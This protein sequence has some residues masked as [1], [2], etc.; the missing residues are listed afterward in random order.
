MTAWI[1][2]PNIFTLATIV[3]IY[4][5]IPKAATITADF[6]KGAGYPL[7]KSKINLYTT[8][9]P[10]TKNFERDIPW[11]AK[12]RPEVLRLE[13]FWGMDQSLS[14]TVSGTATNPVYD[15]A[16]I[17][18]WQKLVVDQGSLV[19]WGYGY[20]PFPLGDGSKNAFKTPPPADPWKRIVSDV[21]THLKGGPVSYHEVWN[22]PN[23]DW[24]FTGGPTDYFKIYENT[25]VA[26]KAVNPDAKV[27]GPTVSLPDWYQGFVQYVQAKNLPLDFFSYHNY[28]EMAHEWTSLVNN[29]LVAD[30][31]F[32]KT[33]TSLDE[34]N[35]YHSWPAGGPQDKFEGANE[36]LFSF[37]GF[38]DRPELTSVFWAQ[39]MDPCDCGGIERLGLLDLNG[40]RKATYNAFRIWAM[41]PVDRNTTQS[42]VA[43]VIAVASSDAHHAG[44]LLLNRTGSDQSI[45]VNFK[46][47]PFA[48]G[49]V[50]VFPIDKTHNSLGDGANEDLTASQTISNASL[51]A[52]SWTGS[53]PN[54]GTLYLDAQDA[55]KESLLNDN[56]VAKI[57]HV[58]HYYPERG[59]TK[60]Y[61]EFDR[62]T[63]I[64]RLGMN[65][66]AVS[67][68]EVGVTAEGL[69]AK[70][71][72]KLKVEGNLVRKD[73][74]SLLGMRIDFQQTD[75]GYSK[76]VLFH[77]SYQGSLDLYDAARTSPMPYG[78]NKQASQSVTVPDLASFS[79]ELAKYA[80]MDWTG[81]TQILFI[82]QNTGETTR[83]IFQI[84]G[85]A[86]SALQFTRNANQYP[87]GS[88]SLLNIGGAT[89]HRVLEVLNLNGKRI[90]R[91]GQSDGLLAPG[92]H[93]LMESH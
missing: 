63:W 38:L 69:P 82:M 17:D 57:I 5:G 75:G 70:L 37:L 11:L 48:T 4:G 29:L 27:G 34:Y 91:Q 28:G 31:R 88:H 8:A 83:A 74:N 59:K 87:K 50:Q 53:I 89:P 85:T 79:V 18:H 77:G 23:F 76:A 72:V 78:S 52:W 45:T 44:L 20:M 86:S 35:I 58:N 68:Q 39:F 42:D 9:I 24:F 22:E 81:R 62:R 49:Q 15:W 32:V 10:S 19:Q 66:S 73:P 6:S 25:S 80:P 56:S 67:D 46:N 40:R 14:R 21:A 64:A 43:K 71:E 30:P 47:V 93:I 84:K 65:G 26:I 7:N 1:R 2:I 90:L 12:L 92:A 16:L 61:S 41:M 54:M 13:F 36:M 51:N 3:I 55:S 33:E 60:A